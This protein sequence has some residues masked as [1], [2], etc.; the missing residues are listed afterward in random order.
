MAVQ[1]TRVCVGIG[2]LDCIVNNSAQVRID[3]R[4]AAS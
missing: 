4:V 1:V 2:E 3:T